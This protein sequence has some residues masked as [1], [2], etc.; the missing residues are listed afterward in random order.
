MILQ[1]K[2]AI[3]TGSSRGIGA[4]TAR[5]LASQG[6][7]VTVNYARSR[8]Q[9]EKVAPGATD[10]DALAFMPKEARDKVAARTPLRRFGKPEDVAGAV[11]FF[12]ADW[13]RFV[14]GTYLPV[15][16]GIQMS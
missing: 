7:K 8:A 4:A 5:L 3:V 14:T 11:L 6:A 12:C 2:V 9:G 15:S 16:G 1:D 13:S 10:T